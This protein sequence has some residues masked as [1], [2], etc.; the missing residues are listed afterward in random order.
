M[1]KC[2]DKT[3]MC[4]LLK[5]D[6]ILIPN[7]QY[8]VNNKIKIDKKKTYFLKSDYGKSPKYCYVIKNGKI[9]KFPT[10]DSFFRKIFFAARKK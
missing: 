8:L 1:D 4:K 10:K 7:T 3:K 6:K 5:K 9:P 2:I